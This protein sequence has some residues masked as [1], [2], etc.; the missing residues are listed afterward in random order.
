MTMLNLVKGL[1]RIHSSAPTVGERSDV[2]RNPT[3]VTQDLLHQSGFLS[4]PHQIEQ[5]LASLRHSRMAMVKVGGGSLMYVLEVGGRDPVYVN[6][7]F[8]AWMTRLT[9]SRLIKN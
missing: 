7:K 4:R 2:Q 1:L 3:D 5:S 9:S 8:A 6:P